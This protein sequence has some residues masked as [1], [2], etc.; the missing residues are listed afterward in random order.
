[1]E[2]AQNLV[3]DAENLF[4]ALGERMWIGCCL[5]ERGHILLAMGG[6]GRACLDEAEAI[7]RSV[8]LGENSD[9][10]KAATALARAQDAFDANRALFRGELLADFREGLR[11]WLAET[12]QL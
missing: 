12:G 7:A 8:G 5:C 2:A 9:L 10:S 3:Q 4:R 6:S 11:Q 1:M